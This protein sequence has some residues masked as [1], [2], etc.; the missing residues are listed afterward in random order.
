MIIILKKS[1]KKEADDGDK[2][3]LNTL[4][5]YFLIYIRILVY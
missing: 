3:F 1:L 2:N 4:L 5:I